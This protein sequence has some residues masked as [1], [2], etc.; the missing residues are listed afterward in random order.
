MGVYL[1]EVS[2]SGLVPDGVA[3]KAGLKAGDVFVKV[4]GKAVGTRAEL[5]RAIQSGGNVKAVVVK[6]AGKEVELRFAWPKK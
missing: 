5:I 3:A 2:V 4:D 1:E 6:R